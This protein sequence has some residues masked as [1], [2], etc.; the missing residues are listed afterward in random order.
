MNFKVTT[1]FERALKRLNKKYPSLKSDYIAF[2]KELEQNPRKGDEIFSSCYKAR[3][4]IKSKGKGKSGG[5]RIIFYFES[6]DD[7]IVLLYVYDKS[8]MENV[9][10][11]YIKQILNKKLFQ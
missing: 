4:A 1:D 8:E 5:G 7:M 9:Q 10:T 11:A 3:I 6:R 2:L